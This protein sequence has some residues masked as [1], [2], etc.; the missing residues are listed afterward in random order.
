V[1]QGQERPEEDE[2]GER[3]AVGLARVL[4]AEGAEGGQAEGAE[5]ECS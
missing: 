4:L 3:Q 1:A 5:A 2:R